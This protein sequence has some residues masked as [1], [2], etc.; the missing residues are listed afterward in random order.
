MN[1]RQLMLRK[2]HVDDR[3]DDLDDAA[4]VSV[5]MHAVLP[6]ALLGT[7]NRDW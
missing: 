3:P 4:D 6:Y 5:R 1:F 7:E 2:L